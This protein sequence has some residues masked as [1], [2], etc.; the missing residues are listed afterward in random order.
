MGRDA[1]EA[2]EEGTRF[3]VIPGDQPHFDE[4][5]NLVNIL[6]EG[7]IEIDQATES[8]RVGDRRYAAGSWII[9]AA[10]A[11]R[12][13]IIDLLEAQKYPD[14]RL[15]PSGSIRPPYDIAGW[16]LPMQM[17]VLVDRITEAPDVDAERVQELV[18]PSPGGVDGNAS[19]GY[20]LDRTTNV[21]VTVANAL[22]D[23]GERVYVATE[24]SDAGAAGSFIIEAGDGTA[25]RVEALAERHGLTFDGLRREPDAERSALSRPVV[26]LYKSYVASMDE[27]WTRWVLEEHGFDV[28]SLHDADVRTADL[29]SLDAIILPHPDGRVF[30]RDDVSEMLNGHSPGSMPDGYTGGM[31]LE[32]ALAIRRFAENGGTVLAFGGAVD[33]AISQLGIP[34]RDVVGS[35]SRSDFSI[36]GS[37]LRATVDTSDPLAWGMDADVAVNFVN[38]SAFDVL[39]QE[40][41]ADDLLNQ[42]NCR[43]VMRGDVPLKAFETES[44]FDSI[45]NYGEIDEESE[46]EAMKD[47]LMSGWAAGTEHIAG[48]SAMARV[49]LG[50]GEVIVYGFRPKFRGQPRGTYKLMFNALLNAT[51]R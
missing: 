41:C 18:A 37:L 22:M 48:K 35:A 33:F 31:G 44:R 2:G 5:I 39:G 29:S 23:A 32:G 7:G 27:G 15:D 28:V 45:V 50:D 34:I 36:P 25:D 47:I 26:G 14:T 43:Q 49:P 10:Q 51:A 42:R 13:Y 38:G 8:F 19:W 12:P 4:A 16:T 6:L 30:F 40:G 24:D 3:Y 46:D 20:A 11:F 21:A 9:P 17:G 1:I